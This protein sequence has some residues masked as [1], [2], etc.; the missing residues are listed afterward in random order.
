MPWCTVPFGAPL[1][2]PSQLYTARLDSKR[3][4]QLSELFVREENGIDPSWKATQ[5]TTNVM[6]LADRLVK[7]N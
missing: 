4:I 5:E 2:Q 6:S 7:E 1:L 3:D